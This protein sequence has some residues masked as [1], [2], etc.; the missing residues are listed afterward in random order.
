MVL[1]LATGRST[2]ELQDWE[3]ETFFVSVSSHPLDRLSHEPVLQS[4]NSSAGR[5]EKPGMI[6]SWAIRYRVVWCW[7]RTRC[8][9]VEIWKTV[10]GMRSIWTITISW[11]TISLT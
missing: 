8:R 10:Q 3:G 6:S 5:P 1:R 7:N 11:E 2:R 9:V 4:K